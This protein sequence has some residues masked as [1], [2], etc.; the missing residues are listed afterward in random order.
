MPATTLTSDWYLVAPNPYEDIEIE[1]PPFEDL[2]SAW[3][4]ADGD[5]T[6]PQVLTKCSDEN[7]GYLV[8][9]RSAGDALVQAENSQK[10]DLDIGH[11]EILQK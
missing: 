8:K 7:Y 6:E 10:T 5:L 1:D 9:A 2:W 4:L 11:V 3:K